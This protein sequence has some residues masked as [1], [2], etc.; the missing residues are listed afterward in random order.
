MFV[1]ILLAAWS[2]AGV[3][4]AVISWRL[5]VAAARPGAVVSLRSERRSLS[6]FKPLSLL[7]GRGLAIESRGLESFI[8]Q[9]D[10][11]CELLLGVHEADWTQVEPFIEK[12]RAL[13][14]D[15]R[16]VVVRRSEPDTCAN[17]KI[18]W[19]KLLVPRATGQVW[20]WSD[21]DIVAPP[22]F[23]AQARAEFETGAEEMLT[24]PYAVR[25]L[26]HPPA[27]WDALF[28]NVEFYPGVL[29]L[30]RF[31]PVDFGLGAGMLFS[32]DSFLRR[33]NWEELGSSLADDF[34][35]GQGMKPVRLS[36][37]TLET[38]TDATSW[39]SALEHYFRW[40]KTV[41]WCQPAG[42]AAQ[43]IIMPL[44]GWLGFVVWNPASPWVWLGLVGMVQAEVLFAMLICR[45]I[46]CR[47]N[48][49]ALLMT[50]AWSL[51]TCP[52]ARLDS[53]QNARKATGIE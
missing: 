20:L 14:P 1:E 47:L 33:V 19:Q 44:F 7:E 4:W 31:G 5:V 3:V 26:P 27:L 43:I 42:F 34:I 35:L 23:L 50:E 40:K 2:S 13:Y 37:M 15:S 24:F 10:G 25:A 21:A 30:R 29:L 36:S 8:A 22:G 28:V 49:P 32:R 45:T 53:L 16:V 6:I 48:L 17:P 18:A 38:A 51:A 52:R 41:C 12:M 11:E 39:G 46:G 9:L